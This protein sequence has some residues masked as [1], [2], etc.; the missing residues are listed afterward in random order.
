MKA[1]KFTNSRFADSFASGVVRISPAF[2]FRIE[3]GLGDGR[4]DVNELIHETDL[5]SSK[6]EAAE[7]TFDPSHPLYPHGVFLEVV[8]GVPREMTFTVTGTVQRDILQGL[9]F[10]CSSSTSDGMSERMAKTFGADALFE[11]SDIDLF[12][13]TLSTHWLLMERMTHKGKVQYLKSDARRRLA[14]P[15]SPLFKDHAFEWQ[16]EYRIVWS[17]FGEEEAF[18][19]E[20]PEISRLLRRVY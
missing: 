16:D 15:T 3:D 8:G 9:L 17:Q 5:P 11:I 13:E 7:T 20:V 2:T 6:G 1:Y 12:A 14:V 4:N 10:C 18:N 19:V